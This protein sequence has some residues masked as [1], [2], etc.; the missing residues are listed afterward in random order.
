MNALRIFTLYGLFCCFCLSLFCPLQS[1]AALSINQESDGSDAHPGDGICEVT[2]GQQD[3]TLRAALM[4][5]HASEIQS[6]EYSFALNDKIILTEGPLPPI[7]LD[8][9]KL[10]S[11]SLNSPIMLEVSGEQTGGIG[12]QIFA[13]NVR[14]NHLVFNRFD[15]AIQVEASGQI[16]LRDSMLGT[17]F[18]G[19]QAFP[20]RVG[21][22]IRSA[23]NQ[24]GGIHPG[25]G[26]IISG[27]SQTGILLDGLEA[28]HNT[29]VRNQIGSD[30]IEGLGNGNQGILIINAG[31]NWIGTEL[32]DSGINFI[33]GNGGAGIRIQGEEARGNIIAKNFIGTEFGS[34]TFGNEGS[35]ILIHDAPETQILDNVISGNDECGIE[36][37]GFLSTEIRI[38]KN[39]IGTDK[40]GEIALGN[41]LDGIKLINVSSIQIGGDEPEQ[42]NVIS[43]NTYSGIFMDGVFTNNRIQG[44]RIGTD[45]EGLFP[46][47]NGAYGIRIQN[48]GSS[49]IGGVNSGSG[50]LIS[51]NGRSGIFLEESG[52][53]NNKILG[54]FIGTDASGAMALGNG[55]HGV[56]ILLS[57]FN[58]VGGSVPGSGNLISGN[59]LSGVLIYGDSVSGN[60]IQGNLIGL[61]ISGTKP[62]GNEAHG[63]HL[64]RIVGHPHWGTQDVGPSGT[65]IGGVSAA[66]RNYISAN[67][68]TGILL[69]GKG[70]HHTQI[71]GNYIGT[72]KLGTQA[73]GNHAQGVRLSTG[74]QEQPLEPKPGPPVYNTLGGLEGTS[75]AGPCLGSCNLISGNGDD[76]I[77]FDGAGITGNVIQSNYIGTD[78]FGVQALPNAGHGVQIAGGHKNW[79]GGFPLDAQSPNSNRNLISGNQG[80]G[81]VLF[82][83]V[84][85]DNKIYG[86]FI[87]SD[88]TGTRALPNAGGVL[89]RFSS[90][91]KIGESV[92]HAGNL[93]SGNLGAGIEIDDSHNTM[94]QGNRIG[95]QWEQSLPLPNQGEGIQIHSSSTS[96]TIGGESPGQ[97]NAIAFNL[98]HGIHIASA[99]NHEVLGN[100][101][102]D[103]GGLGIDLF[104]PGPNF[105]ENSLESSSFPELRSVLPLT[106]ELEVEGAIHGIPESEYR[107]HF[108]SNEDCDSSGYGEGKVYL[109]SD[110][111]LTDVT[112]LGEFVSRIPQKGQGNRIVATTTDSS[113][114]TSEFS[115]CRQIGVGPNLDFDQDGIFNVQDNCPQAS[116]Q[117]QQ[118]MDG[119]GVGDSCDLCPGWDDAEDLDQNQIADCLER[120]V[121]GA[122]QSCAMFPSSSIFSSSKFLIFALW[123]GIPLFFLGIRIRRLPVR[124]FQ[125]SSRFTFFERNRS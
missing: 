59:H 39:K 32:S 92:P 121:Q 21:L 54:N 44:N 38:Q 30:S 83:G 103:N 98:G 99:Q 109:G 88:V 41:G 81:L 7:T 51:A 47:G 58:Q 57:S 111:V 43:G 91:N 45:Q 72:D 94:I 68:Q 116:N 46:L 16:T 105:S 25:E 50:N 8:G 64:L 53:G 4:E 97:E 114:N 20:N 79:V 89:V 13:Q 22:L 100:S 107:I 37:N 115:A 82:G 84:A 71:Q 65:L 19:K 70:I 66:A 33:S 117:E 119:D 29:I 56:E 28:N 63:I 24:I 36:I 42:G 106:L 48:S 104:P 80:R 122:G 69:E 85:K 49:Q 60:E 3:C 124:V 113:R 52:A 31:Q 112:G 11:D 61:D 110:R 74:E 125:D 118:D 1:W 76:G 40:T 73:L 15:V 6:I 87:G 75:W 35:G 120:T 78:V 18:T 95:L 14:L 93:I 17:N 101:I 77:R 123:L 102:Y 27:N 9:L 55:G 2:P 67:G 26:N 62:L 34:E 86:N 90:D 5:A 108:Y 10:G 96:S 23:Y 12:L